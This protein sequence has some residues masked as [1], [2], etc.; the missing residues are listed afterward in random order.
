MICHSVSAGRLSPAAPPR[1]RYWRNTSRSATSLGRIVT[2]T[3][4]RRLLDRMQFERASQRQ[5]SA[6]QLRFVDEGAAMV[7]VDES[8][9]ESEKVGVPHGARVRRVKYAGRPRRNQRPYH[10]DQIGHDRHGVLDVDD[11]RI[12]GELGDE[13]SPA[14]PA[15]CRPACAGGQCPRSVAARA[16]GRRLTS[17][18]SK[19]PTDSRCRLRAS[20]PARGRGHRRCTPSRDAR[21]R[22]CAPRRPPPGRQRADDVRPRRLDGVAFAPVDVG[23]AGLAR[24]SLITASGACA[25][26]AQLRRPVDRRCR[27]RAQVR[28]RRG[29][30]AKRSPRK[31]GAE[32]ERGHRG[33]LRG[34][35]C[36]IG[37]GDLSQAL[38]CNRRPRAETAS[39]RAA[40]FA[41]RPPAAR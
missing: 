34:S 9:I 17:F 18:A 19:P 22:C 32:D 28:H 11:L 29:D 8:T 2:P 39:G 37:T 4:A 16:R 27:P 38:S 31:P 7:R 14:G 12:A 20:P 40:S 1:R 35:E 30:C 10:V 13:V 6:H 33:V 21:D 5:P 36:F 23:P 41:G 25:R 26:N 3:A 15:A 24:G